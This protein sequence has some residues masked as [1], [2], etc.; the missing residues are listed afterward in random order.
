[1]TKFF[2]ALGIF[3]ATILGIIGLIVLMEL[4]KAAFGL[5]FT[6]V[7][8]IGCFMAMFWHIYSQVK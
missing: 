6:V 8:L 4:G 3:I 2:K 5:T 1:M 7:V